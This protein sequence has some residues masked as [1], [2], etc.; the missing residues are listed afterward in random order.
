MTPEDVSAL[1][2]R[3]S[4]HLQELER[5]V[6]ALEHPSQVQP[7]HAEPIVFPSPANLGSTQLPF[8]QSQTGL[9]SIFGRSVLGIAG[10]YVLRA[11]AEAGALP[12]RI[13]VA[14]AAVYAASWLVWAAWPRGQTQLARYSYAITSALI[15]S[16][17]LWESTVRFQILAPPVAAALLAVF[18]LLAI[19][20][21]WYR[22]LS[23]IIW[24]G[25]LAAVITSLVL[26]TATRA[27]VPFTL[28][29]LVMAVSS[30]L[31]GGRDRWAVL[32]AIVAASADLAAL[33]LIIVLGN[34]L[35]VP[36]EY[37]PVAAGVMISIVAA[38]FVIYAISLAIRSLILR[39][40]VTGFE[41]VQVATTVLLA[42]WGILRITN[43]TGERALGVGCLIAGA[44]SYFAAFGLLV[45]RRERSN[46]RFY[47]VCGFAFVIAGSFFALPSQPLVISLCLAAVIAIALGVRQRSPA[48]DLHGV[49]YLTGAVYASG[50]LVYAGRALAGH[51][52]AAPGALSIVAAAAAL[53]CA[54]TLSGYAGERQA[55]R[56]LRLLPAILAV[57]ALTA[58]GVAALVWLIS[59]GA[60]AA[61][62][63]LAVIRTM[64]TCAAAL[65][66]AF[67]GARWKRLELVWLAYAAAILGSLKLV[68]EDLRIGSTE[69]LAAS[70]LIYGT[71]LILIPRLVRVGKAKS[72]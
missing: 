38:L 3:V 29:L 61:L 48:L 44:A 26:M 10:A 37:R 64:A 66:L 62:P 20:L 36:E 47:S 28:A 7:P 8:A 65:A 4:A 25:M 68:F 72:L 40:T 14:F 52:P 53:L 45:R 6:S 31:V 67:V 15:L 58:L 39:L 27:L 23:C 57:Y 24:V 49:A 50:L 34:P 12:A 18:A 63:Q 22:H 5:R 32:R 11:V 33:A 59:R 21:A 17:M 54:A 69:S 1:L 30:E 51:Y 19:S 43:G 13:L 55:E 46:F 41:A 60:P 42:S 2:E 9:F 71:V 16:P 56:L 35:A 70:L